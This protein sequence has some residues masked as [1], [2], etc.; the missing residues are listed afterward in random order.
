MRIKNIITIFYSILICYISLSCKSYSDKVDLNKDYKLKNNQDSVEKCVLIEEINKSIELLEKDA[1]S[2]RLQYS[3]K[4]NCYLTFI[5]TLTSMFIST[6]E[7][8]FIKD[9]DLIA[10]ESDGYVSEYLS[11][12][13]EEIYK[14]NFPGIFYY[15]YNNKKNS[16]EV[17]FIEGVAYEIKVNNNKASLEKYFDDQMKINNFDKDQK[18]Y[19]G[20]LMRKVDEFLKKL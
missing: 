14:N 10:S 15:L 18:K 6:S 1:K 17:F 3:N 9:L 4:D 19:F 2:F 11:S 16:L 20:K 5:D 12:V 8:K 13:C 7:I